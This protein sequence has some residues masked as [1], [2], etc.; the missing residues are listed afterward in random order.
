MLATTSVTGKFA[1]W[2]YQLSVQ[3][4]KQVMEN[5]RPLR[6]CIVV[7]KTE[8]VHDFFFLAYEDLNVGSGSFQRSS[9]LQA[10]RIR[11]DDGGLCIDTCEGTLAIPSRPNDSIAEDTDAKADV[12]G[13]MQIMMC[14]SATICFQPCF[15]NSVETKAHF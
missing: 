12:D 14:R 8:G 6:G 2:L 5:R 9:L 7:L 1:V 3:I 13:V 4:K 15:T 10:T 11:H